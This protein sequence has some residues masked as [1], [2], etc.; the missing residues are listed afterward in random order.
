MNEISAKE[1][2][3]KMNNIENYSIEIALQIVKE[4]E[5]YITNYNKSQLFFDGKQS[6]GKHI[7]SVYGTQKGLY[8][9]ATAKENSKVTFELFGRSKKKTAGKPYFLL[10]SGEFYNSFKIKIDKDSF[11][12]TANTLKEDEEGGLVDIRYT[13]GKNIIGLSETNIRRLKENKIIPQLT[14]DLQQNYFK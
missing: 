4:E 7:Q 5:E 3:N 1:F 13:F 9:K 6:D 14:T 2:L 10:Q 8:S 12:I 11:A